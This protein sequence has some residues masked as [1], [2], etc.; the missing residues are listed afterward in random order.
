MADLKSSPDY[1]QEL[2]L[3]VAS[4]EL[5]KEDFDILVQFF[6]ERNYERSRLYT[7]DR[8]ETTYLKDM[9]SGETKSSNGWAKVYGHGIYKA[10]KKPRNAKNE[11]T[12]KDVTFRAVDV[13]GGDLQ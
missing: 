5:S 2:I 4:R 10:M 8:Q 9:A 13:V 6:N 11:F 3:R 7:S 12:F 1:E